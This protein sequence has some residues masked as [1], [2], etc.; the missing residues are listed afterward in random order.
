MEGHPRRPSRRAAVFIA[1]D[2]RGPVGVARVEAPSHGMRARAPRP[3]PAART[4]A[5]RREGAA[6]RVRS[7]RART[8]RDA[9]QPRGAARERGR[10][11]AVWRRL[12]FE[13]VWVG[14]ATPLDALDARLDEP[15]AR[16]VAR[17]DARAEPTTMVSV[18]RAV[19]QFIPRLEQPDVRANGSWI[20]VA[21]PVLDRD[22]EAHGALRARALRA[23][24]RGHRRA[25]ARGRRRALPALRA[26]P[27]GR[28]VPLG[29]DLLRRARRR[30]TSSRSRRT[31]RSSRA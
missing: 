4:P 8:G 23:A 10:A 11:V 29:A 28:R 24:R 6:Q 14:M 16:R 7:R 1:E 3:C 22:R 26:R 15:Q 13:D 2:E 12:G 25:R 18:E 31:R 5:G 30:A 20:R 17:D 9:P 19:A 21:D 27:D